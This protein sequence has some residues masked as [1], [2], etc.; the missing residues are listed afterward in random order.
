MSSSTQPA[1]KP[2]AASRNADDESYETTRKPAV[3]NSRSSDRRTAASS[4]TTWTVRSADTRLSAIHPGPEGEEENRSAT[5]IRFAPEPTPVRL[6]DRAADHEAQPHP[7]ALARDEWPE[8]FA[9]HF[10]R[11]SGTA[12]RNGDLNRLV[13][14]QGRRHLELAPLR[15]GHRLGRITDQIDEDLLELNAV[16]DDLKSLRIEPER[17]L[18]AGHRGSRQ[19][20]GARLLDQDSQVLDLL[21]GLA[22]CDKVAQSLND[23]RAA[24]RLLRSFV[25]NRLRRVQPLQRILR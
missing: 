20:E 19:G 21:L 18:D 4:S 1:N 5:R 22:A 10:F 8:Q 9:G 15:F 6:H 2:R 7:V 3:S 14:D 25:Q 11:Q 13:V 16:G 24:Q 17:Y 23:V 12:V